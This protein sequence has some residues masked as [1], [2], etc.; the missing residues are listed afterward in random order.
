VVVD[1]QFLQD[2]VD[3]RTRP[4]ERLCRGERRADCRGADVATP[5]ASRTVRGARAPGP[6]GSG[7]PEARPG[8]TSVRD[9]ICA[10]SHV[11]S[12]SLGGVPH[13]CQFTANANLDLSELRGNG[14]TLSCGSAD[15]DRRTSRM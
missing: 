15:S 4:A 13:G 3:Q 2:G 9:R 6:L 11:R 7:L 10:W 12:R 14:V 5:S 1:V 8:R